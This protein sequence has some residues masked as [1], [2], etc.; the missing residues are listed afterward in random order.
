MSSSYNSISLK[1]LYITAAAFTVLYIM[2]SVTAYL[3]SGSVFNALLSD[4]I[5]DNHPEIAMSGKCKAL[6]CAVQIVWLPFLI[7]IFS[8]VGWAFSAKR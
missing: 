2:I 1:K 3:V 7:Y 6:L 4:S 8:C 5:K